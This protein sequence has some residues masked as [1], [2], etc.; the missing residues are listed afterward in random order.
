MTPSVDAPRVVPTLGVMLR[1]LLALSL[2]LVLFGCGDDRR[3]RQPTTGQPG[4]S[5]ATVV[6]LCTECPRPSTTDDLYAWELGLACI[7]EAGEL[8]GVCR[9][10]KLGADSST[11]SAFWDW[12]DLESSYR[13]R[14]AAGQD[15]ARGPCVPR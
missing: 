2:A 11:V 14:Q 8:A 3:G 5:C 1:P 12:L 10:D 15:L 6:E 13:M 4:E 7:D 9:R